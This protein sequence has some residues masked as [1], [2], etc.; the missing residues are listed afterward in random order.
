MKK[1]LLPILLIL[2]ISLIWITLGYCEEEEKKKE[3]IKWCPKT[4]I[5]D[6][7]KC[8][9]CHVMSGGKF[10]LKE[11]KPDAHIDYPTNAKILNYGTNN[12]IGY[13]LMEAISPDLVQEMF[14]FFEQRGIN[15]VIVEVYSY[16]GGLFNAWRIKGLFD[17][18]K[19]ERRIVETRV[20]GGA[21]SAGFLLFCAGTKGY[22][23]V[24]SQAELMWHE[25]QVGQWPEVT[26]PSKEEHKAEIYRHLQDTANKWL[27]TRGNLTKAELDEKVAFKEYW[28]TGVEAVKMGFADK[29]IG[30]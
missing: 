5:S 26:S 27:A 10:R 1:R 15:H 3:P 11:T 25:A 18:W 7:D 12:E 28:F 21:M 19:R 6:N 17:Q 29:L 13:F 24:Q 4:L 8:M 23:F 16:G 14:W 20:Y 9:N 30:N 2:V 22:R